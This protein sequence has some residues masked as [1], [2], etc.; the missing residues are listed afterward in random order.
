MIQWIQTCVCRRERERET[1]TQIN[2]IFDSI[3]CLIEIGFSLP[4][5]LCWSKCIPNRWI[6]PIAKS[7]HNR[8]KVDCINY[9]IHFF[10]SMIQLLE[11]NAIIIAFQM[12]AL[13]F[14]LEWTAAKKTV[15]AIH[16]TDQCANS[17]R[18]FMIFWLHQLAGDCCLIVVYVHQALNSFVWKIQKQAFKMHLAV[19][20]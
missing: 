4:I 3:K 5:S 6:A 11:K 16:W 18:Y 12:N 13:S 9:S 17:E 1:N 20:S 15:I 7:M 10:N 14:I 2:V 8:F 19:G